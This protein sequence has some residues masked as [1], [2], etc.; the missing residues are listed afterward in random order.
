MTAEAS[1][2]ED[3]NDDKVIRRLQRQEVGNPLITKHTTGQL[4]LCNHRLPSSV[5]LP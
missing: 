2:D 1:D 4:M 3:G 5:C